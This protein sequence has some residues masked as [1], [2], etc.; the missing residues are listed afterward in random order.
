M[1]HYL[2][3]QSPNQ[4]QQSMERKGGG[5]AVQTLIVQGI[6]TSSTAGQS[7]AY[8]PFNKVAIREAANGDFWLC[9]NLRWDSNLIDPDGNP[10]WWRRIDPTTVSWA[11][12]IRSYSN[13]PFEANTKGF[14]FWKATPMPVGDP[15]Y[16]VI[17]PWATVGGLELAWLETEYRDLVIGGFGIEIDGAGT[18]PYGRVLHHTWDGTQQTG[19]VTNLFT[20]FS[21]RDNDSAP[22]WWAGRIDDQYLIRRLPGSAA[23]SNANFTDLLTVTASG[24]TVPA[25][26]VGSLGG[27]L[28]AADGVLSGSAAHSD[29]TG[30]GAN[31]HHSQA[32]A[33]TGGDHTVSGVTPGHFLKALTADTFGFAAH[34]LTYSDVGAAPLSHT[35]AWAT[36]TATPTTL[37]GYGI[38]D[39]QGA[40]GYTP[41]N[42]ANK[43]VA[44]GYAG[45]D[46]GGKVPINQLPSSIMQ[47]Q[48]VWDAST[49]TPTL[50]DGVGD[51][52][53]VYRVAVA[54]THNLG[55]GAIT[56]VV[57]DYCI[58][59]G[60]TWEKSDTTDAVASVDGRTGVVTLDDRYAPLAHVGTLTHAQIDG[61]L[62]QAVK[63]TSSPTFADLALTSGLDIGGANITYLD[64][65]D[66]LATA[67]SNAAAGDTLVLAAGTYTLTAGVTVNKALN[68][69]GQ[70]VGQTMITCATDGVIPFQVLA[71]NVRFADMSFT[72]TAAVN[73][74]AIYFTGT[75][76]DVLTGCVVER[77][78][79]AV[80]SAGNFTG[81]YGRDAGG[82]LRGVRMTGS[83]GAGNIAGMYLRNESSAEAA[84]TWQLEDCSIDLLCTAASGTFAAV[85]A[86]DVS[87]TQDVMVHARDCRFRTTKNSTATVYG[88]YAQNG[89]ALIYAEGCTID[90][91][92][93]D[94]AQT[95]GALL[96][97]TNCTLVNNTTSGS[98]TYAGT[99][100]AARVRL[101]DCE[102]YRS[103]ANTLSTDDTLVAAAL[104]IGAAPGSY[105]LFVTKTSTSGAG[106]SARVYANQVISADSTV[107][108]ISTQSV[109]DC[110][111]AA[112][113]T[114]SGYIMGLYN[115]V[116]RNTATDA[117]TLN[118][119]FGNYTY[120]GH[121][122]T[123]QATATTTNAYGLYISP[124]A[125]TGTISNAYDIFLAT[126]TTGGTLTNHWGLYQQDPNTPNYFGGRV[127]V[128]VTAPGGMLH[129]K[130]AA[131]ATIP[132]IAQAYSASQ[133]A[134]LQEWQNSSGTAL[135]KVEAGGVVQAAGYKASDGTAG[136]TATT[137]GLTF[138]NGL[139]TSG[140]V[141]AGSNTQ[142]Q[143]NDGGAL[144][145][146]AGLLWDKTN[147]ALTL[148]TA[149]TA[150][151][152]TQ[153]A[154][155]VRATSSG[156]M[157]N[158]FGPE[159]AF[160]R[161]DTG[162]DA[163][164]ASI[165]VIGGGAMLFRIEH[166]GTGTLYTPVEF[167]ST[168]VVLNDGTSMAVGSSAG[169]MIGTVSSQKLGF[170]GATPV[171]RPET[172][173]DPNGGTTVDAEARTAITAL[174]D[175]LQELGLIA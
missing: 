40:L 12:N 108:A 149:T 41:E 110:T 3:G 129:A 116:L 7:G 157:N 171:D 161:K 72:C 70:G 111:I 81:L 168:G 84:T 91:P 45:L 118:R 97:L 22:S 107:N 152:G 123:I 11:M 8:W 90:G 128:N 71:S 166:L 136:A 130:A 57:G 160:Y 120:Y 86:I 105:P 33:L 113:V 78:D 73:P 140:S 154:Q 146:A 117:G 31:D 92:D 61:Y 53:D 88:L 17:G 44:N 66:D 102:L 29:L 103:A 24:V 106:I 144:A 163:H 16:E 126:P 75:G 23:I 134:S 164:T 121:N 138:K 112:G 43:G 74:R 77:V 6:P 5:T 145:G 83:C 119:I 122:N 65:S 19:V 131:N 60:A 167:R 139:Y 93:A 124:Y 89:D 67:V 169:T 174:I 62:D 104:G 135:A 158:T 54:G 143:F 37:A 1:K 79:I 32:H 150:T 95:N 18:T 141:V 99:M 52:G 125:R 26:T 132:L 42:V 76:G 47:Y 147:S 58:Y 170:Y 127:G 155:I 39:A 28:K 35:Q 30:I 48:G 115:F 68:I 15:Y 94:V 34:G 85:H 151:S 55:A 96:S 165:Q 27:V 114:N 9:T 51:T 82:L 133:S 63:T 172:V 50:A 4:R 175:R 98:I 38:T 36:I 64:I 137:G 10:G 2:P 21:G 100:A 173:A 148:E 56:F 142:L 13:I 156:V 159:V 87:A 59:N 25:L 153:I 162:A 109:A 80:N 46:S 20:D 69:V 14:C 101:D 49:N